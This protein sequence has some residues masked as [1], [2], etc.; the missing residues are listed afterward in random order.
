MQAP[1]YLTNEKAEQLVLKCGNYPKIHAK[2]GG[3]PP[4][5]QPIAD[6][7]AFTKHWLYIQ[8]QVT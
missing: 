5:S 2:C 7:V 3:W 1:A 8:A 4:D 6:C